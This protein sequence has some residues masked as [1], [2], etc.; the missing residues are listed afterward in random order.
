MFK[1]KYKII[2]ISQPIDSATACFPGDVPFSKQVTVSYQQ[3]QVI[4]L[5]ALTMSPH[6]G[7]HAD[8][9]VHIRG[10]MSEEWGMAAEMPLAPFIG[11]V[12]VI[13]VSPITG[14]IELAAI[15]DRLEAMRP[16]EPRVLFRTG[17]E[18]PYD[19][20]TGTYAHF[21]VELVEYLATRDCVLMGIDTPSVDHIDSKDLP[22]HNALLKA[23]ISWLE[24]L[25]LRHVSQGSY[26][27]VALPL[28]FRELE[29]SPVRAVLLGV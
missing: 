9:P 19:K 25:D 10:D 1:G 13:D 20:W 2:D 7:T 11:P 24:N 6:V 26:T 3:S 15:K 27:L 21:T 14:A 22:V 28:K 16:L 23:K 18:I 29:A 8:S 12:H 17:T 4:N 5:T